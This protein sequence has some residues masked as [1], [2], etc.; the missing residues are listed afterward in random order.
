[1]LTILNANPPLVGGM[2]AQ[3]RIATLEANATLEEMTSFC[4]FVVPSHLLAPLKGALMPW[5]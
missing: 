5:I 1:M 3:D 2:F 4:G